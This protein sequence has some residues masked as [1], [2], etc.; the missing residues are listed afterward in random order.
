MEFRLDKDTNPKIILKANNL[1]LDDRWILRNSGFFMQRE[2]GRSVK[3]YVNT[4]PQDKKLQRTRL[5]LAEDY[6]LDRMVLAKTICYDKADLYNA[7]RI[8]YKRGILKAQI[9]ILNDLGSNML[10]EP[11]DYF[12]I[13]NDFDR[14]GLREAGEFKD[15]EPVL[16]L[17]FIPGEVLA[18]KLHNHYDRTFYRKD[19]TEHFTKSVDKINIEAVMRLAGDILAFEE[20]MYEKGYAYTALSPDHIILLADN[21]PRFTGLGWICP[22]SD[23]RYDASHINYG[24]RL[25]KC[26]APELDQSAPDAGRGASV[27]ANVAFGLGL[28]ITSLIFARVRVEEYASKCGDYGGIDE[29][30]DHRQIREAC[31]KK[32]TQVCDL[33][34]ALL[35]GNPSQRLTDFQEIAE[36]LA[37]IS[38]DKIVR[39]NDKNNI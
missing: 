37:V 35:E 10:P 18:D 15:T 14:F 29:I 32:G 4:E 39:R 20:D 24:R 3:A 22:I 12:E 33:L 25:K 11:L 5:A 13:T 38:G 34:A 19:G 36:R 23:D 27:K 7:D 9:K 6:F 31:G 28:L 1:K 26:S 2:E 17:D 21:K 30:M 16:I 8:R